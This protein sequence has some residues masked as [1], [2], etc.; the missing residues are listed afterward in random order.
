MLLH[1]NCFATNASTFLL[2][3]ET[4]SALLGVFVGFFLNSLHHFVIDAKERKRAAKK[5]FIM[6]IH[7][8]LSGKSTK[9]MLTSTYY[10]LPKKIRNSIN[11]TEL[12]ENNDNPMKKENIAK[13]IIE[14]L[15]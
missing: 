11:I 7:N 10:N 6:E 13:K 4:I 9:L 12:M 5:L 8:Y 15:K 14:K 1:C 3:Q 2:S